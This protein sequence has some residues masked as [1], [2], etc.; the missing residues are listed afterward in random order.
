MKMKIT[1]LARGTNIGDLCN[2]V[3]EP[4]ATPPRLHS[5]AIASEPKPHAVVFSSFLRES[6]LGFIQPDSTGGF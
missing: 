6:F 3:V 5:P 4:V 1:R 2:R